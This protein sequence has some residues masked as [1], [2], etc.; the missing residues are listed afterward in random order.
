MSTVDT[1]DTVD[2][3]YTVDTVYTIQTALHC[4]KGNMF[5]YIIREGYCKGL[6]TFWAKCWVTC[7]GG[8]GYP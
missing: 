1:I 3:I 5:A 6:M 2:T 7:D 8:D 4:V